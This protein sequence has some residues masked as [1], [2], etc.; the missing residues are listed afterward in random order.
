MLN[1]KGVTRLENRFTVV[2]KDSKIKDRQIK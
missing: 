2:A 1:Q